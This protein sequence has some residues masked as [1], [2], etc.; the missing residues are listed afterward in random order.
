MKEK[1][2]KK[3]N[4]LC[5]VAIVISI[6]LIPVA[7]KLDNEI[8]RKNVKEIVQISQ[9]ELFTEHPVRIDG[10]QDLQDRF[11]ALMQ[12]CNRIKLPE[13]DLPIRISK[14]SRY[15]YVR[16]VNRTVCILYLEN[17]EIYTTELSS[18]AFY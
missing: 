17:G 15:E 2:D 16:D 1:K 3:V 4:I 7:V 5:T 8:Q 11:D 10:T 18:V 6:I 13:K 9:Q 14:I 12:T